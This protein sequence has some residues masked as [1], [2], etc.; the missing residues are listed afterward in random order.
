[1]DEAGRA[2]VEQEV[3]SLCERK[4]FDGAATK[5]IRGIGGEIFGF[6]VAVHRDET[7]ASDAYSAFTEGLWRGLSSF[8]WDSSLRTWAYAIARNVSRSA[9]RDAARRDRRAP[10]ANTSALH[11]VAHEVRTA[12]LAA[13]KT[14]NKSRVDALRDSLTPEDRELLILRVDRGLA[15]NDLARVMCEDDAPLD[16]DGIAREA[17]RLRKRFQLVKERLRELARREGLIG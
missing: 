13:L 8:G 17:A 1:M 4:D 15:W 2:R 14:E 16:D 11:D 10:R 6:L 9:R 5:A 7:L 12:T 3:R